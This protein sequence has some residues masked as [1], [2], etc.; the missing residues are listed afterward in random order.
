MNTVKKV[1]FNLD[2]NETKIV[3]RIPKIDIV[4]IDGKNNWGYFAL[5]RQYLE[6][7]KNDK[8]YL[9]NKSENDEVTI[10]LPFINDENEEE[11]IENEYSRYIERKDKRK[12][13]KNIK[14]IKI[15][16]LLLLLTCMIFCYEN[17]CYLILFLI[18]CFLGAIFSFSM[19]IY[20]IYKQFKNKLS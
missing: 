12:I 10:N 20:I 13:K 1:I 17:N 6:K 4:G 3:E 19:I 8:K 7:R 16:L 18:I 5:E 14:N 2:L 15:L 11:Y 9:L